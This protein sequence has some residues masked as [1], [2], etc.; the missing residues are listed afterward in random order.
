MHM[1]ACTYD[2]DLLIRFTHVRVHVYMFTWNTD[3]HIRC[4]HSA[5]QRFEAGRKTMLIYTLMVRSCAV[6]KE[7]SVHIRK[8]HGARI[9]ECEG[10][11]APIS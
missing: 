3:L 4:K 5:V 6:R 10:R 2:M 1:S 7:M 11:C 8:Q 9:A